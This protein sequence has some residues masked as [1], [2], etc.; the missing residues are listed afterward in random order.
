VRCAIDLEAALTET[1]REIAELL[2]E[3]RD[4]HLVQ[5]I[6]INTGTVFAGRVGGTTRYEYTVM[7]PAVNLAA[8]LMSAAADGE[9]LL[10]PS[11]RAAVG[12]Q[13]VLGESAPLR[14]KGLAEPV[15]PARVLRVADV[16]M[17]A[18][19]EVASLRAVPLIGRAGE[20]GA[21]LGGAELGLSGQGRV[22]AV[23]GDAGAGKSRLVEE[24]VQRLV[25]GS[26]HRGGAAGV[27]PFE[28]YL[29]DCQSYEQ[30]TPYAALRG[31]LD[32]LLGLSARR[33]GQ[34]VAAI[35]ADV[36]GRVRQ[37]A[38][39]LLRFTPLLGDA[40]G[41]ALPETA[42]SAA[43][44][45]QQRHDRLQE[46]IVALFQGAAARDPLLITLEDVHW[47][48]QP[49][50]E[51]LGRLAAAAAA[52]PLLLVL[53]Y[54]PDP[55]IPAPWDE[56]PE[57]VR[58]RL[59]ELAAADS[60]ALLAA[61]LGVEPPASLLP[62]LER[63]QG[64]PFFIEELVRA[65]ILAGVLVRD[66]LGAWRAARAIDEVELPKSIEGLLIARLDR[67]DE[68]RQELV[69]VA[70]VI[71]RRFQR[72]V[73]EGVYANPAPLGDSLE[74]L[75]SI[76]LIQA[77]LLERNLAYI[78][79][80]A[81]LR[82][83]AYAGILYARRR[84][85]HGR[86]A[87]RIEELSGGDVDPHLPLLAWHYLQ[88]E[89]W[90]AS[91]G[92]HLSAAEQARSRFANHDALALYGAALD[93]APKLATSADPAWLVEQVATIHERLGDLH[94][95]LGSYDSAEHDYG[96]A[97]A[98]SA[99]GDSATSERWLRMHRLLATVEE[100]RSRY[101]AAF[102]RLRPGMARASS[103]QRAER[104]RCYQLGAGIYYRQGDYPLAMEWARLGLAL[105]AQAGDQEGQARALKLIGNIFREQGDLQQAINRL[106]QARAR[107]EE[108][109]ELGGLCEALNDLG[110][111]YTRAGRWQET[112][113]SFERSLQ[114]SESIGDVLA[115]ARTANNL[116]V[117]LVG[118]NELAR[119]GDLYRRS[120]E[121]FGRIGSPLGVAVTTW[122][123][124]EV[125]LLQ[126]RPAEAAPLFH[127][128]LAIVER[129]NAR[130]FLPDVLRLN[131]EGS[132]ALG[133]A[134]AARDYAARSL[135]IAAEL[136]MGAEAAAARRTLGLV[137]LAE[138]DLAAAHDQLT[139]SYDE[140][141]QLDDRYELGKTL[142]Q[143]AR[144]ALARGDS[145]AFAEARERASAIFHELDAQRDLAQLRAL[146]QRNPLVLRVE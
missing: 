144:L 126:G 139:Q 100:R 81:L 95:L 8:R 93:I 83:V 123:R 44:N 19:T 40:L 59:G 36:E 5:K 105:A 112:I 24:L 17:R 63:T 124:G 21:L 58:V 25:M 45:P 122:N 56:R 79:R 118:R 11:T 48:D 60:A 50:L 121:G 28:I 13:F 72:P 15:T 109:N 116:A 127:E 47:A 110:I 106:E 69:Q 120:S 51:L 111:V 80:H 89:E 96:Q 88:A 90:L 138:G 2:R 14:L 97:L 146:D 74:R 64:N 113:A 1:N 54:R 117:L 30:R 43:L 10:S 92:Y 33:P 99:A 84:V 26:I 101:E 73:I 76:E 3:T 114:I 104:A 52:R 142:Y 143:L 78:F 75:V 23:V 82:D 135:A 27:P 107:F 115:A 32:D 87:R 66:D 108:L 137:A 34:D 125:L 9:L 132:L 18:H 71:G 38:P 68:A 131:A 91:L 136:G 39:E 12:S 55:P 67:L 41:L 65:L 29:G 16:D 102:E 42:L 49:S 119:A 31:P 145:A 77:E 46:L 20:L 57:T 133:E 4:V 7:G 86:V 140:L 130:N 141:A 61:L 35:A 53:T 94:M 70:S 62:L 128:G 103:A 134:A 6:G 22:L 85:L 37:L 98:L 129:I